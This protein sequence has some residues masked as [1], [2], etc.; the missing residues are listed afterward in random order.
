MII[1]IASYP[2]SGNTWVRSL[3]ATY[4]YECK[5]TEVFKNIKK[6]IVFPSPIHFKGIFEINEFSKDELK[7]KN[8]RDKR[9]FEICKHWISAQEQINLKK[10]TTFLKTHNMSGSVY[11]ND[12]TNDKNTSGAIYIV[13]DPRS[14]VVSKA[15]HDNISFDRSVDDLLDEKIFSTNPGNLLEF[16]SSWKVNYQS[17]KNRSFPKVI[18]R[19]EDLLSD[20]FEIFKKILSFINNFQKIEIDEKK[21]T[22]TINTCNFKNLSKLEDAIG[23]GEREKSDKFFRKGLINEW[24]SKLNHNQI[25]KIENALSKEMKDLN[26]L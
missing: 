18:I 20:T 8:K 13:R 7:D 16:R 15:Y 21:I 11:G 14:V 23:F 1:W 17:W 5:E 10:E 3:I 19:Y 6:I 22:K 24:K 25:K 4:L 26:Y 12:F 2:K 9:K